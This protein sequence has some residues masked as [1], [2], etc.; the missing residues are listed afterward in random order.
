M[1]GGLAATMQALRPSGG[2]GSPSRQGR[3]VRSI[4]NAMSR[5]VPLRTALLL[6]AAAAGA[7]GRQPSGGPPRVAVTVARAERRAVPYQLGATGTV[8]PIRAVAVLP[9]VEGTVL[10]VRFDEGD[11]VVSGQILFQVDARPYQAA[12]LQAEAAVSRDLVQADNAARDAARY[13]VLA[14]M[15]NHVDSITGTVLLKGRFANGDGQL[16]PGEFVDVTL[17]L[18]IEA[19]AL[20]VPAQAVM[21]SQQ[22]T[23]VFIVNGDGSA[24]QQPVTVARTVDSLAVIAQGVTPGALVVTDGQLRLT[25]NAR[26]DIRGGLGSESAGGSIR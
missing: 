6:V 9:R 8:E 18:A 13:G 21:S 19:D 7:C 14:F 20:V 5:T 25:P 1:S 3:L 23:Y 12:L 4:V 15:D 2:R 16:W 26:V 11:E 17:V 24:S 22:G 10:R